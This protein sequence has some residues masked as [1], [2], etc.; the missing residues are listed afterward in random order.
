MIIQNT[1]VM[2]EI[3]RKILCLLDGDSSLSLT[4]LGQNTGISPQLVRYRL[5]KMENDGVILAYWPM[6]DF[7]KLGYS[8]VSYFLKLKNLNAERER[9]VL[10]LLKGNNDITIVMRGDGYWDLHFTISTKSVFRAVE[11]F[12]GF[13]SRFSENI[14]HYETAIS[15]GFSQFKRGYLCPTQKEPER[16]PMAYTGGDVEELSL[17]ATERKILESLNENGRRSYSEIARN[18]GVSREVVAYGIRKLE[19]LGVIQSY[20]ILLDQEKI[21]FP[22]YRVLLRLA[23]VES[24]RF[25]EFFDYCAG[26]GNITSFLRLFGNWQ[27]LID[28]EIA[29]REELRALFRDIMNRYSDIVLQIENTQVYSIDAFRDIPERIG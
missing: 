8:N 15:V 11:I 29:N 4:V 6:I 25:N 3:D 14:A 18:M 16:K 21:G 13:Q 5:Q 12:D 7:R 1:K 26:Q 17:S 9:D 28:V 24:D 22:R 2:E 23:H 20:A 27:A 19:R 10:R